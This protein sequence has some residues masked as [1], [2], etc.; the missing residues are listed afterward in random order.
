MEEDRAKAKQFPASEEQSK[1]ARFSTDEDEKRYYDSER[2]AHSMK[3]Q[4]ER[5]KKTT[6]RLT[7]QNLVEGTRSQATN[8]IE[9]EKLDLPLVGNEVN[10]ANI[11]E[12][13]QENGN[14]YKG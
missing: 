9:Q 11:S 3:Q 8:L 5:V 2:D 6:K 13:V 7:Q 4:A 12:H 10:H 1:D 14:G